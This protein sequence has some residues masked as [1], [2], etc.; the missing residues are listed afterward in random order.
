MHQIPVSILVFG[1]ATGLFFWAHV[2][3]ALTLRFALRHDPRA[4]G[5]IFAS[6][7]ASGLILHKSWQM[8]VRLFFPWVAAFDMN[9]HP[10]SLKV[11]LWSARLAGTGLIVSFLLLVGAFVRLASGSA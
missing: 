8:R 2:V 3:V 4:V 11:L 1:T 7:P 9:G 10:T 6:E 5:A